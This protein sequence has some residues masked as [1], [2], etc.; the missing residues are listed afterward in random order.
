MN[1]QELMRDNPGLTR[2]VW[3]A[4]GLHE[5]GEPASEYTRGQAEL[6]AD[7][8]G[9]GEPADQVR[10]TLM[11]WITTADLVET[12]HYA[13]ERVILANGTVRYWRIDRKPAEGVLNMPGT[14]E[15][16]TMAGLLAALEAESTRPREN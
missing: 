15:R 14:L 7:M 5:P 12:E 1:R 3:L 9:L 2:V 6:I 4:R 10:E 13:A 8:F 16:S 11:S